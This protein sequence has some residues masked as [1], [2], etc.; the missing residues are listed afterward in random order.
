MYYACSTQLVRLERDLLLYLMKIAGG[1]DV[2]FRRSAPPEWT[3]LSVPL[4]ELG[5]H[6]SGRNTVDSPS[7][8]S[9]QSDAAELRH[10]CDRRGWRRR[11]GGGRG[12][13]GVMF[14]Q[15]MTL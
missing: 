12:R 2:V 15:R 8:Q 13:V 10:G 1:R 4:P 7:R 9:T 3:L 14:D 11:P 5:A 6:V